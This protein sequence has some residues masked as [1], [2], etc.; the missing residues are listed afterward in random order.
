MRRH[1]GLIVTWGLRFHKDVLPWH[2]WASQDLLTVSSPDLI[3]HA[4][5]LVGKTPPLASFPISWTN[6]PQS[7]NPQPN[8][9]HVS[10]KTRQPS[11]PVTT[12]ANSHSPLQSAVRC[13]MQCPPFLHG[14]FMS[15]INC[16]KCHLF[17]V[18]HFI[19]FRAE[20][21]WFCLHPPHSSDSLSHPP[22]PCARS[23]H[24]T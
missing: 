21:T 15:P 16:Y 22:S 11:P 7:N 23:F 17:H 4:P 14:D 13:G 19:L 9:F 3:K 24:I 18:G 20:R 10:T 5:P 1:E 6:Q 2:L 12:K 8:K